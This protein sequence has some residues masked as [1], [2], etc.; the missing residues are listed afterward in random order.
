LIAATST[1]ACARSASR[2]DLS[3]K[4][5]QKAQDLLVNRA[6]SCKSCL[7][8]S[9]ISFAETLAE[10]VNA[11]NGPKSCVAGMLVMKSLFIEV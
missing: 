1:G 4:K 10:I 8:A 3:H 11:K 9:Q 2:T 7:M 5:A 6:Q